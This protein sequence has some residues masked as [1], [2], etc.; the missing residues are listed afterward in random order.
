MV[1]MKRGEFDRMTEVI[2]QQISKFLRVLPKDSGLHA[3][4]NYVKR[5]IDVLQRYSRILS[6]EMRRQ[7]L[8]CEALLAVHEK[9][10]D[11]ADKRTFAISPEN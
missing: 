5:I 10:A 9:E 1:T 11:Q 6:K 3:H 4:Y 7:L 8:T 2:H